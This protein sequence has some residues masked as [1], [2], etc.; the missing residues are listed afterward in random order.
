[1]SGSNSAYDCSSSGC[2]CH[3]EGHC[4]APLERL[5]PAD[6]RALEIILARAGGKA[7]N[8][9]TIVDRSSL[10]DR[11]ICYS[12]SQSWREDQCE[13]KSSTS[14]SARIFSRHRVR[15]PEMPLPPPPIHSLG[16]R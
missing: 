14:G 2:R 5:V 10:M 1:M 3:I 8:K 12:H 13:L 11:P 4:A 15:I 6:A 9:D 7:E 16:N